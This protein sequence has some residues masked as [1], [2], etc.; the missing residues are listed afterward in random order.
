MPETMTTVAT[1]DDYGG[2]QALVDDMSDDGFPV[3]N[4]RIV[5]NQLRMVEQITGRVTKGK[6]ALYGMG[7]GA[8]FALLAAVVVGLFLPAPVWLYL[9]GY[10]LFFGLI[11]GALWGFLGHAA[12][13][14]MRD[15]GSVQALRAGSYD[16]Q[17][18][19]HLVD[20]AR[21]YVSRST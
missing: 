2:A 9:I 20:R 1:F 4:V 11:F 12:T 10:S 21:R 13:R 6:A 5:G 18:A 14:G 3:Q 7:T 8:W 17:V 16:V 15:F 19:A